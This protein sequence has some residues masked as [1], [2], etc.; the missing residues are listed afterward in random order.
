MVD[1]SPLH[2][3]AA[4]L[5]RGVRRRSLLALALFALFACVA[6]TRVAHAGGNASVAPDAGNMLTSYTFSVSG[7]NPGNG[8]DIVIFDAAE[9]RFTYQK[10]GVDQAIVVDQNGNA[11]IAIVP[12]RDLPGAKPGGWRVVFTEEE[13]GNVV[14]LTFTVSPANG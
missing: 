4:C 12:G 11:A 3:A 5:D 7:L 10:D 13:S 1:R 6:M 8:V 2:A 9:S 14:T